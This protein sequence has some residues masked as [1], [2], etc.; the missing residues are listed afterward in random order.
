QGSQEWLDVRRTMITAT[1]SAVILGLSPWKSS[2]RLWLEKKGE[3]APEL[4]T[5]AMEWGKEHESDARDDLNLKLGFAN[6]EPLVVVADDG[7]R[8]ASLDGYDNG[9][10]CEIKC[11]MYV[12]SSSH[13]MAQNG[14]VAPYY[15][16]QIQH[17]LSVCDAQQCHYYSWH[18]ETGGFLITVQ[19]DDAFIAKMI[20]A[21]RVFFDSL[22]G[23]EDWQVVNMKAKLYAEYAKQIKIAEAQMELLKPQLVESGFTQFDDLA[24]TFV[25]PSVTNDYRAAWESLGLADCELDPFKKQKNGYATLK[26][27]AVKTAK[28]DSQEQ[29][30]A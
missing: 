18:T 2:S 28:N 13:V 15:Y 23:V 21:E 17:Q 7:W 22:Q 14:E 30:A 9:V 16:S 10:L 3:L 12:D 8:M 29:E 11:P 24:I 25:K 19:R 1:D 26:V 5:E 20:E 6:F 4:T 27:R